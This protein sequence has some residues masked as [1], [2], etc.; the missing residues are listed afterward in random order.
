MQKP[1]T[2]TN[3][4]EDLFDEIYTS[5]LHKVQFYANSYLHD[6]EAAKNV[7]QEVFVYIW[8]NRD[9]IDFERD[10]LPYILVLARNRC[11]N[12]L[13]RN[14]VERRFQEFSKSKDKES[15]NYLTL[16]DSSEKL[17][18]RDVENILNSAMSKMSESVRATFYLN[19]F[20]NMKYKE[21]AEKQ[22]ISVKTVE[23]RIM[24]ALKI[25]RVKFKDYLKL[26]LGLLL[27][28]V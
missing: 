23:F 16:L 19:R 8:E 11:L 4:F 20:E 24:S 15:L 21:I 18:S 5:F 12:F 17:Y 14:K 25:L 28:N 3:D 27:I 7:T 10:P 9:I 6:T 1:R 26:F 22:G 2:N 13:R